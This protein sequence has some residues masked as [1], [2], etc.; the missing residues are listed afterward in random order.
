MGALLCNDA[1]LVPPDDGTANWK[2]R[3][4]PTEAALEVVAMKGGLDYQE[5]RRRLPGSGRFL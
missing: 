2:E 4:D 1:Q 3:G 5:E